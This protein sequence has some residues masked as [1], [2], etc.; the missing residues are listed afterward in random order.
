ML[1]HTRTDLASEAHALLSPTVTEYDGIAAHEEELHG[2]HV[3][4]VEILNANGAALINKP[5]GKYYTLTLNGRFERGA[6]QFTSAAC[7]I[8]ELIRRCAGVDNIGSCLVA[9]LGNPDITPDAV[10]SIAASNI[11]VT[12]HLKKGSVPGFE[13][14]SSSALCRTGVLGT[15]GVESAAQIRALVDVVRPQFVI[16]VDA[17][18]GSDMSTLCRTVQVCSSGI[19]PGS[20]VG[21][22]REAL[23]EDTL[24]VPVIAIGVPTVIDASAFADNKE[25][26]GMFVTP[27]DI[28]SLVRAAG[29]LIGYGINLAVHKGLRV[30]DIDMLVG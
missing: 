29:K 7:A 27:R 19:A 25:L 11:L 16:A 10:G 5:I 18:A 26:K 3:V 14:F 4:S 9:A 12:R 17:L 22:D 30:E 1:L 15:T 24:G 2:L 20:G 28:D 8:G 6:Q 21:N 13:G 23:C